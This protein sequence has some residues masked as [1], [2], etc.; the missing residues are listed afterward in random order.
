MDALQ[1]HKANSC[2]GNSSNLYKWKSAIKHP[3]ETDLSLNKLI[4]DREPESSV[5]P[6]PPPKVLPQNVIF[7]P[8]DI[9]TLKSKLSVLIGEFAAGNTTT[10]NQIV[11]ILDNLRERNELSEADYR[12][13]NSLLQ[14][15]DASSVVHM[16]DV[17]EHLTPV[18]CDD[19]EHMIKVTRKDLVNEAYNRIK[20][21]LDEMKKDGTDRD[22][23]KLSMLINRYVNGEVA[24]EDDLRQELRSFENSKGKKSVVLE[25]KLLINE[26]VYQFYRVRQIFER[27]SNIDA[28]QLDD[29]LNGMV[30]E[31]LINT[32]L[33]DELAVLP[34]I[35]YTKLRTM[36]NQEGSPPIVGH[37]VTT[38]VEEL[39]NSSDELLEMLERTI[40]DHGKSDRLLSELM[41]RNVISR[42]Q[43]NEMTKDIQQKPVEE[44]YADLVSGNG[45]WSNFV[46]GLVTNNL[47]KS[48]VNKV[49]KPAAKNV[50]VNIAK[51]LGRAALDNI[52]KIEP[53]KQ[54]YLDEIPCR[55][56]KIRRR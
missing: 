54:S 48:I 32:K 1:R 28:D 55:D 35:T 4:N 43:Y 56:C 25:V 38:D 6:I 33:R 53:T 11:A 39:L 3:T 37:D 10:R 30:Y 34:C 52:G 2:P 42:E 21:L 19:I 50:A 24:V 45:V 46:N 18:D 44:V 17:A 31:K 12:Y 5:K 26:I 16:E 49:V 20:K 7:L 40:A 15:Y 47:G 29:I 36:L 14:S 23:T 8:S 22:L 13:T 27:L 41:K 9:S 51:K